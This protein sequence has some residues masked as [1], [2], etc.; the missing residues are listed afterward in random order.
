MAGAHFC[1]P[2][3]QAV[4]EGQITK[5]YVVFKTHLD[6]GFTDLAERVV[7]KY[8]HGFIPRSIKLAETM[9]K[10]HPEN[11]FRWTTGSWLIHTF[12]E[13]ADGPSRKRMERA[14]EAG[15]IRWHALPF[16]LHSEALDASLFDLG[17]TLSATL[18]DRFGRKTVAAKMTDVPGHTRGIVPRLQKAGIKFL[19]IGVNPASR[20]PEV[21]P[22][23]VW[24]A[25]D[26]SSVSVMY[27]K[28][29][30]G[31][32]RIPHTSEA[33]AIVFTGDNHG[34]Q[35]EDDI[36]NVYH[37]LKKQFSGAKIVASDLS[38]IGNTISSISSRLPVVNGELGDS[39]IHG[40]GSDPKKIA[41]LRELSR[42][43]KTWIRSGSLQEGGA[44]D[45]VFGIPLAMIA[46]HTWGLDV[47]SHLKSWDVYTPEALRIARTTD[48]FQCVESSWQEKRQYVQDAV[49][50]LPEGMNKQAKAALDSLKPIFPD[51]DRFKNIRNPGNT[52]ES[53]QFSIALNPV[54]GALNKLQNRK[55]GR[56][57]AS[58]DHPLALF[59]YQTFSKADYDRFMNQYL[60]A[61]FGWA[62]Q[63]FGKPGMEKFEPLSRVYLPRLKSA[64]RREDE[65]TC[66]ILV[67]LEVLDETGTAISGCPERLTTEYTISKTEPAIEMTLQ[68]FG[69]QANRLPEA[70][71]L[72]F[73]PAVDNDGNWV[74][75]K[76]GQD[77]DPRHVVDNGG[78]KMHAVAED[79]RYSDSRDTVVIETLDA[80]LVAPGERTLLNFDNANPSP[81]EGMHFCLYNNVWG[82]N[83]VM[84]FDD[85]MRFR[86]KLRC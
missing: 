44:E 78:H 38:E 22:V 10:A 34:P 33:V 85:D 43:R 63:D 70:M 50:S 8:L 84:W 64:W 83:F 39:W 42:L 36:I 77:V 7:Q 74:M 15:D 35:S 14:I 60:T 41:Q 81:K 67:E 25:P 71:W 9:R 21:P 82:T 49:R 53:T 73:V 23:F 54:T 58:A 55:T 24:Q 47:K 3:A 80:P 62:L 68:W 30:G 75:D 79:I 40:I 28:D 51:L 46:E 59:S 66:S 11:R 32:M 69:K 17:T 19:H 57:W 76:M 12:L 72:S 18:D 26:G 20:P 1:L 6:I 29:Y 16:T 27:Q 86:F 37:R 52:I 13:E 48:R 45:L 56:Q 65:K 5:V 31:V 4:P 2:L 61:R